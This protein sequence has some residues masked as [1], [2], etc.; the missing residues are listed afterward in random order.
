MQF[1]LTTNTWVFLSL[2]IANTIFWIYV[3][4]KLVALI[5][6]LYI[7]YS[8]KTKGK[9]DDQLAPILGNFLKGLVIFIGFL[10][11]L[12]LFGVDGATVITGA[13]IGGLAVALASQDTV[14]NL[15]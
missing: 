8:K 4:L 2:N 11:L 1:S 12:T 13:S 5:T 9:L 10:N 14:K 7:D 15:I 3:F 6:G